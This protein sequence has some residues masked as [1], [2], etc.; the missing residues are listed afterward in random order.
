MP[1]GSGEVH[2]IGTNG[3]DG[4]EVV[5]SKTVGIDFNTHSSFYID[6]SFS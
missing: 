1:V 5:E 2:I 6:I 4:E 3:R